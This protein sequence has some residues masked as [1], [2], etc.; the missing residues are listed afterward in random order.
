MKVVLGNKTY[1][2]KERLKVRELLDKINLPPHR[3]LVV[4]NG[5]MALENEYLELKDEVRIISIMS[6]G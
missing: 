5:K 2:F 4:R 6:G 3:H 1:Q